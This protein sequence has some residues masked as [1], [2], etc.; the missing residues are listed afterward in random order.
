MTGSAAGRRP[1]QVRW[2][3]RTAY[4]DSNA[5]QHAL[6]RRGTDNWLLLQEHEHTYTLGVRADPRHLLVDPAKAGAAVVTADRGGDITYHGPGQLVAYP[7]VE[8]PGHRGGTKPS[9]RDYIESLEQLVIDTLGR[10]G[11]S[12]AGRHGGFPGV[13]IAPPGERPRKI[14]AIGVRLV[15]RRTMHG[16]ALN[17]APDMAMFGQ[18]VPCGITEFGVT[19]MVAEGSAATMAE[20]CAVVAELANERWGNGSAADLV[21][22]IDPGSHADGALASA[23]GSVVDPASIAHLSAASA[24]TPRHTARRDQAGV[25][26]TVELRVRKPEWMR[27]QMRHNQPVLDTRHVTADL[28]LVTVCEE[29]GCPNLS[30]CW[31][32]G[33]ATFMLNGERCTRACG[34]CLVDTRKPG[35]VDRTEPARVAEAVARLGLDFAVLTTVA[36]DD[37]PDGG[38][39]SMAEAVRQIRAKRPGTRV[40][41]LISDCA[42]DPDSLAVIFESRPDVLNHNIET[43]ARLQ[44]MARPSAGYARS[45][46]VLARAAGEGL[47]TKSGMVLGMGET[48]DEIFSTLVDLAGVGVQIVTMGQYLRPT[49]AH[50]P[51]ARY[52]EPDAFDRFAEMAAQVGIEHA[53]SSPF[54]RSSH[55]AAEAFAAVAQAVPV[56]LKR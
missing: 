18:I 42:G 54:T 39:W 53:E 6:A 7:I 26:Q 35:A 28:G 12:H 16:F 48:E 40:E 24:S 1:L 52:W 2:L 25:T 47:V 11:I 4:R 8:L 14:A 50:L 55:H 27:A 20:V 43:V 45:L 44:R 9:T 37:L 36:R 5:L 23:V 17:V 38:A 49:A 56:E 41:L 30:E 32:D 31:A 34:F 19:S 46:A 15:G 13:W 22:V 29:A 3:G 10:F 21:Q 33:T 51:V